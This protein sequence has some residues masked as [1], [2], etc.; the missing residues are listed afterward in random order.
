MLDMLEAALSYADRKWAVLPLHGLREGN[1]TC[2]KS[3]CHS[4]GKHPLTA[5][6]VKDATTDAAQIKEWWRKWPFANIGIATGDRSGLIVLDIDGEDGEIALQSLGIV[7]NPLISITGRG[8]HLFFAHFGLPIK[9]RTSLAP[10]LDV[11]ADNGYVVAPPSRHASGSRYEWTTE[12]TRTQL[13][14]GHL[15]DELL[16]ILTAPGKPASFLDKSAENAIATGERNTKLT[17]IAGSLFA[18]GLPIE[19]V[20]EQCVQENELR[21]IPPLSEIEVSGIVKSIEKR[22]FAK[23]RDKARNHASP[24]P[25]N[26]TKEAF[27]GLAGE[28]VELIAPQSESDPAALLSQF[29]VVF[30]NAVG[31]NPHSIVEADR[32]GVN[33]FL[34]IV[35]KTGKGRKGTSLGHILRLFRE[36][37]PNWFAYN[38]KSGLSSGEGL[39]YSV[40]DAIEIDN[41]SGERGNSTRKG[42]NPDAGIAD[43]RL[44]LR[45]SEFAGLLKTMSR[46]GNTVS[47]VVRLAWDCGNLQIVNKN[48]PIRASDAHISIIGHITGD[49]LKRHLKETEIANGFLNRFLL[50]GSQRSK[51]LPEGGAIPSADFSRLA[52]RLKECL[53]KAAAIGLMA[54]SEEARELWHIEYER[55][56]AD[57]PGLF[58]AAIS[59]AEAHVQRLSCIYALLDCSFVIEVPHLRAALAVWEYAENSAAFL[60][61]RVLGDPIADELLRFIRET[62]NGVSLTAIRD[63]FARHNSKDIHNRLN[64][65]SEQGKILC[66]P[67]QPTSGRPAV[68]WRATKATE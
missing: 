40:R 1:C 32:H 26:L 63:H 33:T 15:P 18:R 56:S 9:N 10:K 17:A 52:A 36:A 55:L 2:G 27:Y 31:R 13:S 38:I 57:R 51:L 59:R 30:G 58:G 22:E 35:G 5:N 66:D 12:S 37:D 42:N 44:L 53:T 62:P 68:I 47:P 61:G 7:G 46:E 60:F 4:S 24:W 34:L 50:I 25:A 20:L 21:C 65:F 29:L 48:S 64:L 28:I 11:R 14:P 8:R 49:E 23:T 41:S 45:E 16:R 67:G 43:K 19:K 6:G 3:D 39:I 54:R